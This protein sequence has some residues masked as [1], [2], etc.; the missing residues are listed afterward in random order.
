MEINEKEV[1][2]ITI[3]EIKG[4]IMADNRNELK[5]KFASL[6]ENG[7][8]KIVLNFK[9]IYVIDSS[10]IGLLIST[11][12]KVREKNGDI[13][14]L[15]ISGFAKRTFNVTGLNNIFHIFSSQ[16]KAVGSFSVGDNF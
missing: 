4:D 14:I 9:D 15:N 12:Q 13:K 11:L 10:G 16:D 1:D 3:L 6:I 2:G 7:K 5:V 8:I